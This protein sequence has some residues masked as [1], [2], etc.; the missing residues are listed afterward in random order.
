MDAAAPSNSIAISWWGEALMAP[1]SAPTRAYALAPPANTCE[2]YMLRLSFWS[3][4]LLDPPRFR[5]ANCCER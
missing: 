2:V 4:F 1:L 3:Y 5:F